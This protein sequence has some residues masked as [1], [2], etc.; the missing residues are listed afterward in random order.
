MTLQAIIFD[1]DGTLTDSEEAHRDA[2][3]ETFREFGIGVHWDADRYGE[4][5]QIAGGRERLLFYLENYEPVFEPSCCNGLADLV[6][7]LHQRKSEIYARI[8]AG[9]RLRLRAGVARLI[10]EARAAGI[11]LAIATTTSSAN[12]RWLIRDTLGVEPSDLFDVVCTGDDGD[13]KKPA[14]D[15][16]QRVLGGLG[17]AGDTCLVIED[18]EIGL[19]AAMGAGIPVLITVNAYTREQNFAGAVAVVSGLGSDD[20]REMGMQLEGDFVLP[21]RIGI[22][23]VVALHRH[24]WDV[25]AGGSVVAL[26][27]G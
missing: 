11:R 6:V 25:L 22:A 20:D 5:L 17:L 13:A 1:V 26:G 27:Y 2:F 7:N 4:L 9:G 18:S 12:V 24:Q 3:N 19:R 16:Y 15:I 10:D 23:D 21:A 14:P 8:V